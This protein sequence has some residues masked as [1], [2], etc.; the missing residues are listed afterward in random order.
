MNNQTNPQ[1][2]LFYQI[3]QMAEGHKTVYNSLGTNDFYSATHCMQA[4]RLYAMAILSVCLSVT[5]VISVTTARNISSNFSHLQL[6]S[7][8][9]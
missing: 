9:F 1:C 5:F 8:S 7:Q 3:Y 6:V 4:R 2:T